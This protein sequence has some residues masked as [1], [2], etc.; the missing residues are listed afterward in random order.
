MS[1][2]KIKKPLILVALI[3]VSLFSCANSNH[4]TFGE[5]LVQDYVAELRKEGM[6]GDFSAS[7]RKYF[8][9]YGDCCV[10]DFDLSLTSPKQWWIS[11]FNYYDELAI[12]FW[13]DTG[14]ATT[15]W[16]NHEFVYLPDL[17][18]DGDVTCGD[19]LSI[20]LIQENPQLEDRKPLDEPFV[21]MDVKPAEEEWGGV[22]SGS[23]LREK[24]CFEYAERY[25]SFTERYLDGLDEAKKAS[26]SAK[27]RAWIEHYFGMVGEAHIVEMGLLGY[28]ND[29][30]DR[31]L[32]DPPSWKSETHSMILRFSELGAI[33]MPVLYKDGA[34]FNLNE[35]FLNVFRVQPLDFAW[36]MGRILPLTQEDVEMTREKILAESTFDDSVLDE[37]AP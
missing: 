8:G 17:F 9:R 10:M 32:V 1:P 4:P 35:S 7:I 33:R 12:S 6:T 34:F 18:A 28:P 24:I 11:G 19:L 22:P 16:L 31:E 21:D 23:T 13:N 29:C 30:L 36:P 20:K 15:A 37:V 25:K 5:V 27:P 14:S 3:S 26:E 2:A